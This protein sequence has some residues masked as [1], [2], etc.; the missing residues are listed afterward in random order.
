MIRVYVAGA[1]SGPDVL[2]V[3]DNMRRG[4]KLASEVFAL[5][6]SPFTP[7][8]DWPIHMQEHIDLDTC[9]EA[10]MAWLEVA[11]AVLVVAHQS[12]F[13]SKGTQAEITRADE[14]GIP[15]FYS[16]AELE[17]WADAN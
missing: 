6:Y 8:C 12:S 11:D 2:T 10:S 9:Y 15:V 17:E 4:I 16:L 13:T 14:L 1:Y 3:F 5:G 7:W